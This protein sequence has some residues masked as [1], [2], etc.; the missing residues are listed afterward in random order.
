[1]EVLF[2]VLSGYELLEDGIG[3]I[4]GFI[5]KK[6]IFFWLIEVGVFVKDQKLLYLYKGKMNLGY[7]WVIIVGVFCGCCNDV[8]ILFYFEE[9][10]GSRLY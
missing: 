3:G 10:C 9:Y 7:G 4:N 2:F 5:I 1:M 6:N 8:F